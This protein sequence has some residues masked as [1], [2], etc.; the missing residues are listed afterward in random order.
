MRQQG[1]SRSCDYAQPNGSTVA[2]VH[3]QHL[4]VCDSIMHACFCRTKDREQLVIV[5][6]K[7]LQVAAEMGATSASTS[8]S[9]ACGDLL[10][11]LKILATCPMA[12]E[13]D[14]TSAIV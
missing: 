1:D 2:T 8:F 12:Y 14:R 4:P 5:A 9:L 6:V 10:E 13:I 7:S 3:V 11:L